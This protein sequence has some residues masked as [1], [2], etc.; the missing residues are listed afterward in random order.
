MENESLGNAKLRVSRSY[1]YTLHNWPSA[2]FYAVVFRDIRV[3]RPR[4]TL[5]WWRWGFATK[6]SN[7]S[8]IMI[9]LFAVSIFP[10]HTFR[11]DLAWRRIMGGNG[12]RACLW[13]ERWLDWFTFFTFVVIPL[14]RSWFTVSHS[15]YL[16]ALHQQPSCCAGHFVQ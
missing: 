14:R 7:F 2:T 16:F 5:S 15:V 12:W 3:S 8:L 6:K 9:F 4:E 11:A 1:G 10:F 13:I